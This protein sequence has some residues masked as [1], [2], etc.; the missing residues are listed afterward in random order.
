VSEPAE[1]ARPK[2]AEGA[3]T[4][5]RFRRTRRVLAVFFGLL[6][7]LLV[8]VLVSGW[9]AFGDAAEG[10]R[11]AAME[12]SPQW[13]DGVFANP[14]PLD[15]DVWGMLTGAFGKSA[16]AVP[17]DPL[18]IVE[19]EPASFAE[20]PP[21][22]LRITWLGHSTLL[23]ELDGLVILTDP[24]W[25]ERSSPLTWI[26]PQRWYPPPIAL[27]DLPEIDAVLISHDHYDHLDMPTI[28]A[29]RE[30]DTTFVVPLGVGAHLAYWGVPADRI[31]A[32]D[33]WDRHALD[34]RVE[35]V[36][37]PS[38]HASGRQVLDQ[39]GTLWAG[40]ALLGPLHRVYFS[41][42]TGLFRGMREIGERLGP[43]DVTM[44]EVGAY[45]RAW[46]DWHLGPENAVRAHQWVRGETM[47]PIHWGLFDLAYHGWTEPVERTRVAARAADVTLLTPR[48]GESIEPATTPVIAPWWPEVP[49]ETAAEH[50]IETTRVD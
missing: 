39:N 29:I 10:D 48:P 16:Y 30:W 13:D 9:R 50:P 15:N 5:K 49:W 34:E 24:V 43:F 45:D 26:G 32:L 18:P 27:E 17:E 6:A 3:E 33:W 47:I 23:I 42:D 35:L 14:D 44:I 46:P 2:G 36:C 12:A 22:G 11:R 1:P 41:G 20:P 37:V 31:V 40:Y 21:S 19:P 28:E 25:G 7:I 4:P 38:R 8:V